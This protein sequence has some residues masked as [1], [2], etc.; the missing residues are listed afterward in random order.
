MP[1]PETR[2]ELKAIAE[3]AAGD[4]LR[5]HESKE[6]YVEG[7]QR[8]SIFT[9]APDADVI[10]NVDS[11]EIWTDATWAM[12][13]SELGY[14]G[15]SIKIPLRHFWRSF[16]RAVINDGAAP[17]RVIFPKGN[18]ALH[19]IA[20][21]SVNLLHLGYAQNATITLYKS[22]IHGHRGDWRPEWYETK[23]LANAQVDVHP[24]NVNYWNPVAVNPDEYFPEWMKTHEN[25]RKAIVE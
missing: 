3:Q 22:L 21:L 15:Y 9:Y 5:W 4:K 14:K 18:K 6:W 17:D 2:D 11:D 10:L 23:F 7:V 16:S 13:D 1:C 20:P 24:T 12:L 8:D 25:Y 19:L